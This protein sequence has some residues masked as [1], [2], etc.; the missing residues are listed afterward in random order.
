MELYIKLCRL[1]A[2]LRLKRK[3]GNDLGDVPNSV[4]DSGVFVQ[5][6]LSRVQEKPTS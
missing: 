3:R 2:R 1:V 6:P 5:N 4:N